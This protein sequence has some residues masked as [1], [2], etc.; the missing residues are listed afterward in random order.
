MLARSSDGD[1]DAFDEIIGLVYAD[2]RRIAH[3]RLLSE[4]PDH[5]LNTTALVHEAYLSLVDQAEA[6]WRGR[7]H[8]FAVAARVIRNVLVDHAR[9]RGA[10]KRGGGAVF[11][12]LREDL[13]GASERTIELLSLDEALAG[14]SRQD[15]ALGRVVECRFFGGMTHGETA[16]ALGMSVRTVERSWT[17]AK[18]YL[19]RM[20]TDRPDESAGPLA[21]A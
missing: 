12:P 14:L 10:E 4:R 5:T 9:E 3:R 15:E 21:G 18:A 7:A 2:L 6:D 20:L 16:E 13:D 19:Y 1:T 11:I 17:R 8:F